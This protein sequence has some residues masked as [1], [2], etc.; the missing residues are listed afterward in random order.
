VNDKCYKACSLFGVNE[1]WDTLL[2]VKNMLYAWIRKL[3]HIY[4]VSP[5]KKYIYD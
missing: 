3:M 4:D 1:E 5:L 2:P